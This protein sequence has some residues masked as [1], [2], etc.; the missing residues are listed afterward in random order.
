M[1]LLNGL[2][3]CMDQQDLHRAGLP[4][5]RGAVENLRRNGF[6][7]DLIVDIGANIGDWTLAFSPV[8]PEANILMIDALHE[9]EGALSKVATRLGTRASYRICVLGSRSGDV[10]PFYKLGTGSS[11]FSEATGFEQ[12]VEDRVTTTLDDILTAPTGRTFLKLDVQG[13]E[14]EVLRG[15]SR[16][17][18][19]VEV[20][21]LETSLLPYNAGAPLAT[22]VFTFMTNNGFALYDIGGML[23]RYSDQAMFQADLVFVRSES[24]LRGYSAFWKDE[25]RSIANSNE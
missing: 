21:L 8:F 6:R 5:M 23:R 2:R 11:I 7:P 24:H 12:Q 18:S 17:L 15:S 16:T 1:L 25:P 10:V 19:K 20:V 9:C 14:L 3:R 13:A 22:E 4:N